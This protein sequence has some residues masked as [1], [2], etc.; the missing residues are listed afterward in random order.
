MNLSHLDCSFWGI[1]IHYLK[2]LQDQVICMYRIEIVE[3]NLEKK[4][5]ALGNSPKKAKR[6]SAS[7]HNESNISK[8]SLDG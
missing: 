1:H 2:K 3:K 6:P 8:T 4:S 7:K 5:N